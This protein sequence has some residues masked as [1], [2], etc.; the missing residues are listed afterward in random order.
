MSKQLALF[1][2]AEPIDQSAAISC[3]PVC[4]FGEPTISLHPLCGA[5]VLRLCALFDQGVQAGRWDA[6]G[7]TPADRRAQQRRQQRVAK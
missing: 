2:S 4:R 1:D 5:E 7:Y 6:Q 3:G